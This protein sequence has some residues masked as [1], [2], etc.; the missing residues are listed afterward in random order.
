MS[1][2]FDV[3][4]E[5]TEK[6]RY[7]I[8]LLEKEFYGIELEVVLEI[9]CM[10]AITEIPQLPAFVKGIINL[11]GRIIPVIDM[12]LK[13]KKP[14]QPYNDR[15]CIIVLEFN[16]IVIGLIVDKVSDVEKL[17][18]NN[19]DFFEQ[20]C[21]CFKNKYIKGI[22]KTQNKMCLILDYQ[23]L[24]SEEEIEGLKELEC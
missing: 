6:D 10:Q 5:Y 20:S 18:E 4:E 23:K 12:R 21:R 17:S 7:L 13:L 16:E 24:L 15:T 8:F 22:G 11:R 14:E 9:I 2:K 19:I 3:L 1:E